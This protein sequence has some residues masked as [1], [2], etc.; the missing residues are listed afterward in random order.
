MP[1]II[2]GK[3]CGANCYIH[4]QNAYPGIGNRFTSKYCKKVFLGFEGAEKVFKQKTKTS[5]T[6]NPV[7]AEFTNLDRLNRERN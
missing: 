7:R 5:Y 3:I 6:G 2:A 4:E 1:V